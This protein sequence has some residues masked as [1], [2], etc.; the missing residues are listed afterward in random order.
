MGGR[1]PSN[2]STAERSAL[3]VGGTLVGA[4]TQ[5]P[6]YYMYSVCSPLRKHDIKKLLRQGASKS[7]VA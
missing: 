1:F 4:G 5:L 7:R 2:A 3:C 6:L